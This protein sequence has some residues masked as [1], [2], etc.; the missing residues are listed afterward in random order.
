MHSC[1]SGRGGRREGRKGAQVQ[2]S[3]K[4]GPL[5]GERGGDRVAASLCSRNEPPGLLPTAAEC[6]PRLPLGPD[7]PRCASPA[8]WAVHSSVPEVSRGKGRRQRERNNSPGNRPQ[9][10]SLCQNVTEFS[11]SRY[12]GLMGCCVGKGARERISRIFHYKG[13]RQRSVKT[14]LSVISKCHFS[15]R[16]SM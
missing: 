14:P 1:H 4:A 2:G 11:S 13:K 8:H 16:W 6:W 10:C 12:S 9:A 3:C 15:S 7:F 5:P